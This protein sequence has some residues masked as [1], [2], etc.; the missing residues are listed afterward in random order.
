LFE[1]LALINPRSKSRFVSSNY[2]V[3]VAANGSA[4]RDYAFYAGGFTLPSAGRWLLVATSGH[5][6]GCFIVSVQKPSE[7]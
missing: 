2:A 1:D 4:T 5:D 7:N 6:W 3:P